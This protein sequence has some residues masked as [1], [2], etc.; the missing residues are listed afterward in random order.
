[1]SADAWTGA[2]RVIDESACPLCLRENCEGDCQTEPTDARERTVPRLRAYA[3]SEILMAPQPVAIV[4]GVAY[5]DRVTALVGESG[6]GKTFAALDLMAHVSAGM[7]WHG[8]DVEH[9]SV[10][11]ASFE[12]DAI[13]RR[14]RAQQELQGHKLEHVYVI[15]A[16]DPISPRVTRDGEE[17]SA[18]EL[19]LAAALDDL[20][21][22]LLAQSRPRIVLITID[23]VRASMIGSEDASEH[24]SAYLRA[25]RRILAQ[26]AGA[27]L[28]LTHHAGWQDGETPRKRERGSSAWRGNVDCTLYLERGE[29]DRDRGTCEL[30][31]RTLKARDDEPAAP[32]RLIRRRVELAEQDRHGRPV[33]SCVIERDRR[34]PEDRE[35][36]QVAATD[37]E[38]QRTDLSILRVLAEHP[39]ATSHRA[40]RAFAGISANTVSESLTRIVGRRG[41][42]RPPLKQRQPYTLTEAGRAALSGESL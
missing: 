19:H 42:A 3:A 16:S 5:A 10:V 14:L 6:A 2:A 30:T 11:I 15:R 28:L 22:S 38:H 41:W 20:A 8:R 23:T 36:Q 35:A 39:E 9:G 18:G 21:A 12:G 33:T 17:R 4:E 40:V 32:L 27:A 34:T 31:L 24:V 1:M 29:Y 25:G 7:R 13:G 26:H 37:L